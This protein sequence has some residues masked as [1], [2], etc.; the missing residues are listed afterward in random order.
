MNQT[1]HNP[2]FIVVGFNDIREEFKSQ[3][4]NMH[5]D[6]KFIEPEKTGQLK[7]AFDG[8]EKT[9]QKCIIAV[10]H[11]SLGKYAS[12]LT[13][14]KVLNESIPLSQQRPSL[15]T[16]P[17]DIHSPIDVTKWLVKSTKNF[18]ELCTCIKNKFHLKKRLHLP[19]IEVLLK[20]IIGV[21]EARPSYTEYAH[22][23]RIVRGLVKSIGTKKSV[24]VGFFLREIGV[25]PTKEID[26][27]PLFSSPPA[28]ETAKIRKHIRGIF[29]SHASA[30][31]RY[32][33]CTIGKLKKNIADLC[34]NLLRK[35]LYNLARNEI[36]KTKK[37]WKWVNVFYEFEIKV[38]R[39]RKY[40]VKSVGINI[41]ER[42]R[43]SG[44]PARV[45][46]ILSRGEKSGENLLKDFHKNKL[47]ELLAQH[48]K[49]VG[50]LQFHLNHVAMLNEDALGIE[51]CLGR[52][53]LTVLDPFIEGSKKMTQQI[54]KL[55]RTVEQRRA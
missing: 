32:T 6:S 7:E 5:K 45:R 23:R 1:T 3:F 9:I 19:L 50:A 42:S 52:E 36:H 28:D 13:S 48:T 30:L 10:E 16:G 17:I 26:E 4:T 22:P 18:E 55:L 34:M 47:N 15:N 39:R 46:F 29:I 38:G 14:F 44:L 31:R 37:K 41:Y 54:N 27:I 12:L 20:E 49:V 2:R 43:A 51:L 11:E 35:T 8:R 33:S 24:S 53:N 25:E 21:V 40:A